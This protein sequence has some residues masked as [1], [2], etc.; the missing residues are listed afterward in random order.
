MY[1]IELP[2]RNYLEKVSDDWH[3]EHR[4]MGTLRG[5]YKVY[6]F[7]KRKKNEEWVFVINPEGTQ[8]VV[9]C[10]LTRRLRA[11]QECYHPDYTRTDSRYRGKNLALNLYI[12]L[13]KKG[14]ILQAGEQQS[15]GSQKLWL[16]LAKQPNNTWN[17]C[18]PCN[19]ENIIDTDSW[20]PYQEN[21][22]TFAIYT[23]N[24]PIGRRK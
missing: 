18:F 13:L 19:I 20:H 1:P 8:V 4:Y 22:Y 6:S 9:D 23:K 7:I 11:G 14:V 5:G 16:K 2:K 10:P 17:N 24:K 15:R 12:F 21:C 3:S